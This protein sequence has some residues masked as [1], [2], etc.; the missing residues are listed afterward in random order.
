MKYSNNNKMS[1]HVGTGYVGCLSTEQ[2]EKL[3]T[4][5]RLVFDELLVSPSVAAYKTLSE[6]Q[7]LCQSYRE[8]YRSNDRMLLRFLRA[9]KFDLD[10]ASKFLVDYFEW[11]A[12]FGADSIRLEQLNKDLL[13]D[14]R[15][16]FMGQDRVGRPTVVVYPGNHTPGSC[17]VDD[18]LRVM[19]YTL[20]TL[21]TWMPPEAE[22][23]NII[24]DYAGWGLRNVDSA[25]D[26][27]ILRMGSDC[28]PEILG[29]A[30]LLDAPWYFRGVWHVIKPLLDEETRQKVRMIRTGDSAS[31]LTEYFDSDQLLE[32]FG[33]KLPSLRSIGELL[34]E[35]HQQPHSSYKSKHARPKLRPTPSDAVMDPRT[36]GVSPS[37]DPL[38]QPPSTSSQQQQ[39]QQD[40][41]TAAATASPFKSSFDRSSLDGKATVVMA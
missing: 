4:F 7:P 17:N 1:N 32:K 31:V 10:K 12:T 29:T 24:I 20:E 22:K 2:C 13:Q 25:I 23:L 27:A 19:V 26:R 30:F 40:D 33:G 11:R 3:E 38:P 6:Q 35:I 41:T 14:T 39:Q 15:I 36:F 37:E 34:D 9:R 21:L 28:F 5:R 18:M 16:R 8:R